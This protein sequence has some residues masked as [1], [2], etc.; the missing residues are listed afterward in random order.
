MTTTTIGTSDLMTPPLVLGGNT[1][2]WTSDEAASFAVLDAFTAAGGTLVDTADAYSVWAPGNVGGESETVIGRWLAARRR[3]LLVATKVSQHP[4]HPGLSRASV[5]GALEAS[6]RRLGTDHVDLYYAHFDDAATPLAETVQA[7][8]DLQRD[9]KIR[10]VG[11]S[12][13]TAARLAEWL[14]VAADLHVP[15]PVALQPHYNLV[16]RAGFETAL[17]PLALEHGLGVLPYYGLASGFLTGKYRTEADTTGAARGGRAA[18]YLAGGGA[19]VLGVLDEVA[20]AHAV[21]PAAVALAW[22]RTRPTVVAPIASV[23]RA[24]QLD[25]LLAATTLTLAPD[26]AAALDEVSQG[27]DL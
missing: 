22:L 8:A 9:G 7:F 24:D 4:R 18:S 20:A 25:D 2:G 23:S 13:Y 6:L 26:E 5:H 19:P 14:S 12:N 21:T 10:H 27:L 3:P 15:A 17:A 1:F 16:H 11:V